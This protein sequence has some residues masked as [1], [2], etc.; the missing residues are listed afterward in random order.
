MLYFVYS[1]LQTEFYARNVR[2]NMLKNEMQC[3]G[4]IKFQ[5]VFTT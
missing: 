4:L 3:F 5:V 1:K 2:L